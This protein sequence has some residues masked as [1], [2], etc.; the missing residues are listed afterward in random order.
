MIQ[1]WDEWL[2]HQRPVL[3][4]RGT[5]AGEMAHRNLNKCSTRKCQILHLGRNNPMHQKRL[6]PDW[7]ERSFTEKDLRVLVGNKLN[8]NQQCILVAG[9]ASSILDCITSR[10]RKVILPLH[11]GE[12]YLEYQ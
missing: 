5:W 6:R 4:F 2:K 1:N 12:T 7:L 10:P 8:M 11:T 9:K 3:L